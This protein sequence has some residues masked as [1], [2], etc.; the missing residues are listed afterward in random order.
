[1]QSFDYKKESHAKQRAIPNELICN[2]DLRYVLNKFNFLI[3]LYIAYPKTTE[4]TT[5]K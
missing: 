4:K 2:S 5:E 1:M 3:F